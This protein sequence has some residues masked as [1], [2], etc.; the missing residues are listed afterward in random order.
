MKR[1]IM[2]VLM[3]WVLAFAASAQFSPG[4]NEE[5]AAEQRRQGGSATPESVLK[6]LAERGSADAQT[7]LCSGYMTGRGFPQNDSLAFSWCEKAAHQGQPYGMYSLGVAYQFGR[8]TRSDIGQAMAAY[9]AASKLGLPE[10]AVQ[11]GEIYR[12]GQNGIRIDYPEAVKWYRIGAD[13]G[14]A[15]GQFLMGLMYQE[16]RGVS[17]NDAQAAYWYQKAAQ[18]NHPNAQAQLAGLYARGSG[19]PHDLA[20]AFRWAKPAAEQGSAE[21]QYLLATLYTSGVAP[22]TSD[23]QAFAWYTKSAMQNHADA[24]F[25][26]GVMYFMGKGTARNY[27]QAK[28]WL[29]RAGAQGELEAYPLLAKIE[30]EGLITGRPD[31][32]AGVVIA[33]KAARKGNERAAHYVHEWLPALPHVVL[34]VEL[35][36]KDEP[37]LTGPVVATIGAGATV[38]LL[39]GTDPKTGAQQVFGEQGY[40]MGWVPATA[41][42]SATASDPASGVSVRN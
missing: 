8:G 2:S 35:A 24:Q 29:E 6:A 30:A 18:Q 10:A 20:Q 42:R 23:T 22:Q 1:R 16:A 12:Q 38:Y 32:A 40:S 39:P 9:I 4:F 14:N 11:L 26:L 28:L 15:D 27:S 19:V 37:S 5:L 36:L 31:P 3:L 34:P 33:S 17:Q 21:A 7:G 41:L 13:A 25:Q